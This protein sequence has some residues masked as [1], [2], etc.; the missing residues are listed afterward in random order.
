[1]TPERWQRVKQ[2]LDVALDLEDW[3]RETFVIKECSGDTTLSSEVLDLLAGAAAADH[4][5]EEPAARLLAASEQRLAAGHRLG[6]YR[7]LREIGHG[8]MGSVYLAERD[9]AEYEKRVAIK[10]VRR[11]MDSEEIVRRF[12][13]ERQILANLA[14]P[15]I[16][17]LLDGGTT[18]DGLSY[19]VMEYVEGTPVDQYCRAFALPQRARLELFLTICSAVHFAHQNLV[20]HR[21]L[22]PANILV[23]AAGVPKLLDFG[24]AKLLQAE[25]PL[26]TSVLQ[27]GLLL[28]T[29]EYASPE[30]RRGG[31][32]TTATDVY[33]LGL[34]LH[35][36]LL[37]RLPQRDARAAPAAPAT[38]SGGSPAKPADDGAPCEPIS[39]RTWAVLRGDLGNIVAKALR[40]EP[41]RR[42]ASAQALAEDVS[43]HLEG[44]PVA[45]RPDTWGY[46]A[47]K[48]VRR[49]RAGV[50]IA[51]LLLLM[52]LA[53]GATVTVLLGRSVRQQRRAEHVSAFLEDLFAIPDPGKSRG[54]TISARE[55]L[56]RGKGRIVAGLREDPET[57]AALMETMGRVYANLGL[58][59]PAMQLTRKAVQLRRAALGNNDPKLAESLH[60]LAN[61]LRKTGAAAAA[62]PYLREAV[63]IQR[64]HAIGDDPELAR[65]LNNLATFLED[66]GETAEAERL[67]REALAMKRRIYGNEHADVA[68]AL[69]NLAELLQ[70]KGDLTAAEPLFREALAIYRRRFG[71]PHPA[72]AMTLNNLA[73]LREDRGDLT[74]AE[75]LQRETLAMRRRLFGD[76]PEVARSLNNLGHLR[77]A[78]GDAAGAEALYRQAIAIYYQPRLSLRHPD[79][80]TF[81]RNLASLLAAH[82]DAAKA[83]PLAREALSVFQ[84]AAPAHWRTADAESVLGGCLTGLGRY[85]EAEPLLLD[86]YRR[87]AQSSGEG[88]QHLREAVRRLVDLYTASKRDDRAALYR[89]LP[90]AS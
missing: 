6:P 1:M 33:G 86:G 34:L 3:K 36:L 84:A 68:M 58:Y 8:G 42:Y 37:G 7:V 82:G 4:F 11:G 63:A 49:H 61:L 83:E 41:A 21:D 47:G 9:D 28:M 74:E 73:T 24:I 51:S 19:F 18:S 2:L 17:A 67:Y 48:F 88:R 81:L 12:R 60:S 20:V 16:A 39:A 52:I 15:N 90:D 50:S 78:R 59:E 22:K 56:D 76:G 55:I 85:A 46:R 35:L 57:R 79:R 14:H 72:I 40:E 77:E 26:S 45:A 25:Q 71:D 87:L 38:A 65:G 75:R 64:R 13:Q 32:I 23:T 44:M 53:F 62:E 29:P 70:N 31:Q 69:N 54:E 89:A 27:P 66:R 80:A 10:V 5:I 43:R 30:Q